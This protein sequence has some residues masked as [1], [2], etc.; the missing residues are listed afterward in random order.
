MM[1][2][3]PENA[4]EVLDTYFHLLD[5]K[6][7]DFLEAF[8]IYGSISLGAFT[9]GWSDLDFIAVVK[10]KVTANELIILKKVHRD[11]HRKFPKTILDGKYITRSEMQQ[12]NEGEKPYLLF[13]EGK[14]RGIRP[15]NKDSIDAFQLKMYGIAIKGHDP[16]EYD[17]SVDWDILIQNMYGNLNSYWV[18]WR[19]KCERFLSL[20]YVGLL[21]KLNMIEWG[22]LGVSRIYY[23]FKEK[24]ITSKVGAGEYALRSVP[25]RWHKIINESMRLRKG[26]PESYYSS[27]FKLRNDALDYI[28]YIIGESNSLL[29]M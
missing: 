24:Q 4:N 17:Y 2:P 15:F 23:T 18:N 5:S 19:I 9:K 21:F 6:L 16:N 29:C 28:N 22:V 27:I 8:F 12:L 25:E 26:I 13:N 10:R 3:L 14:Y 11:I 1:N 7:L 20:S